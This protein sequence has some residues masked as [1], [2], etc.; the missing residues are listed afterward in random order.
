MA[1]ANALGVVTPRTT[2]E[3]RP[4]PAPIANAPLGLQATR[5][6]R[7]PPQPTSGLTDIVPDVLPSSATVALDDRAMLDVVTVAP[8]PVARRSSRRL[9]V[10]IGSV[11]A[12]IAIVAV[13][14]VAGSSTGDSTAAPKTTPREPI[15]PIAKPEPAPTVPPEPVVP[16]DAVAP[17]LAQA[18]KHLARRWRDGAIDLLVKARRTYPEDARLPY[19][20]GL[21][22]MEK[23][24]WPD[25]LKQLRAA[26]AL[27]PALRN[28]PALI[29]AAIR[30]YTATAQID[31]SLADF[32]RTDIG[33]AARPYLEDVAANDKN[34]FVR[35]RARAELDRA[36]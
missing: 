12:L 35:N 27:D 15:A 31:W 19:R 34:A 30:A 29:K 25:G 13:A 11:V 21:L 28:D 7:P 6:L 20:A 10:A 16:D 22:Y 33:D 8:P 36:R 1:F 3:P 5:P 26:I 18:D 23:L 9:V 2:P 14:I 4:V 17:I 24:W 32:L